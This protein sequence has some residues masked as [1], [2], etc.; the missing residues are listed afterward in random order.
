MGTNKS[1]L[2]VKVIEIVLHDC[3]FDECQEQFPLKDIE[4]HEKVCRHRIV[5]C[6]YF[7]ICGAKVPLS[8]LSHTP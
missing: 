8:K 5:A 1:I 6:P 3:K 2:A 4:D 7:D